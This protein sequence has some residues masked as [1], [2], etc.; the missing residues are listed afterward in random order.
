MELQENSEEF[1]QRVEK[2]VRRSMPR[3][4]L[5]PGH[6]FGIRQNENCRRFSGTFSACRERSR[7]H[8]VKPGNWRK[9]PI[10]LRF[11]HG[12][13]RARCASIVRERFVQRRVAGG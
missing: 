11:V 12:S 7:F 4:E 9:T 13:I 1:F 8:A 6:F 2:K 10:C 3:I 5:K